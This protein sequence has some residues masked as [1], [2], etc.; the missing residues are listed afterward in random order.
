[1]AIANDEAA[2][3]EAPETTADLI[4]RLSRRLTTTLIVVAGIVG[5]AIYARPAPPRYQAFA[6]G[7]QIVRI[8]TRTGTVI[9]CE[10]GQTCV[11]LLRRGQHLAHRP[12]PETLPK[13]AAATPL[14]AAPAAGK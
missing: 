11:T 8:D 1:M 10:D 5:L 3:A 4:E 2:A 6:A 9:G 14:P 12:K 7:S 13:P